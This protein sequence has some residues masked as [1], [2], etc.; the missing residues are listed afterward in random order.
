MEENG[1]LITGMTRS[2]L[3]AISCILYFYERHLWNFAAPSVKRTKQII[4]VQLLLV[5][6]Q[7][8]SETGIAALSRDDVGYIETAIHV[9]TA[10]AREKIPPTPQ[11]DELLAN[12]EDLREFLVDTCR[13]PDP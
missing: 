11:R 6:I 3:N 10:Q 7:L 2:H 12:C 9:F 1:N 5:K 13:R 4:E 8:L